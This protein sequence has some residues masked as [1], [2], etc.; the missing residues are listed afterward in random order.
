M[1][2]RISTLITHYGYPGYLAACV[3]AAL[4]QSYE[5]I[6]II[7]IDD[8]SPGDSAE[9][10]L[11]R[12]HLKVDQI[13]R[14]TDQVGYSAA[15]QLG[16]RASTGAFIL[17]FDSDD[18]LHREFCRLTLN[19]LL[20]ANADACYT[21]VRFFGD[22][23]AVVD[24][25]ITMVALL[26]FSAG[27][28]SI[29]YRRAMLE[30]VNGFR[31]GNV[32]TDCQLLIDLLSH[33]A[34]LKRLR[35]P[36]Y[37]Y[38]Q[39]GAGMSKASF[40]ERIRQRVQINKDLYTDNL[41][42]I[43]YRSVSEYE[44]LLHEY[45]NIL[46]SYRT[47]ESNCLIMTKQYERLLEWDRYPGRD[48]RSKAAD[49]IS[50][51]RQMGDNQSAQ[52]LPDANLSH[53]AL[54]PNDSVGLQYPTAPDSDDTQSTI[55][56][57]GLP[58][59]K[60]QTNQHRH[61]NNPK[62]I[63]RV[64][65]ASAGIAGPSRSGGMDA[66][67]TNL[68][69]AL[70][71]A[72]HDV[73]I[74]YASKNCEVE[75]LE[76][77]Q[78]EFARKQV[79]FVPLPTFL[80]Q[81]LANAQ[82]QAS[83]EAYIW[84]K[85]QQFDII[86]FPEY[87]GLGYYT[88]LAKRQGLA[89]QDTLIRIGAHSSTAWCNEAS[90]RFPD[91]ADEL[92]LEFMEKECLERA[93][94]VISPSQY[95]LNWLARSGIKLPAKS[96]V[97]HGIVTPEARLPER[98]TT[99]TMH[100]IDEIVFFGR[101]EERK[102]LRI[103]CDAVDRLVGQNVPDFSV[104]FMGRVMT[105]DGRS[106]ADYIAERGR[107]WPFAW[108]I[109]SDMDR[110]EAVS[111]LRNG[112]RLAVMPSLDEV[113]GQ[114]VMECIGSAIPF[115]TSQAGGMAESIATED[116]PKTTFRPN[117][118]ELAQKLIQVLA[119]GAYRARPSF[120]PDENENVW[121]E[122][123]NHLAA[124]KNS[125]DSAET[126]DIF[127][128]VEVLAEPPLVTV[129]LTNFDSVESLL[130]II[131][132]VDQQD[133]RNMEL[134]VVGD[135]GQAEAIDSLQAL[136]PTFASGQRRFLRLEKRTGEE[137]RNLAARHAHGTYL[138]FMDGKSY[139][140]AQLLST[141]IL[142]TLRTGA[143]ITTCGVDYFSGR[144]SPASGQ[145]PRATSIPLGASTTACLSPRLFGESTALVCRETFLR[146]G[147][148]SDEGS[149]DCK[150]WELFAKAV[151]QGFKLEAIPEALLWTRSQIVSV[152]SNPS[153]PSNSWDSSTPSYNDQ[154]RLLRIYENAVANSGKEYLPVLKGLLLRAEA[155]QRVE[156]EYHLLEPEYRK[157]LAAYRQLEKDYLSQAEKLTARHESRPSDFEGTNHFEG[158]NHAKL[159]L[160]IQITAPDYLK[161]TSA[162]DVKPSTATSDSPSAAAVDKYAS[163]FED[164]P[165]SEEDRASV[166]RQADPSKTAA[167]TEFLEQSERPVQRSLERR[168]RDLVVNTSVW[169]SQGN[170]W[171]ESV[172]GVGNDSK[173]TRTADGV[174]AQN[175][176]SDL[177]RLRA[178]GFI[179][180]A[181]YKQQCAR[182]GL[183]F[184]DASTHYLEE[185]W[186][187]ELS[188]S[189]FFDTAYYNQEA[190][191]SGIQI[192]GCPALHFLE[193]GFKLGLSP[194]EKF[195]VNWYLTEYPDV[196]ES[197]MNP[198]THFVRFG[199]RE[200]RKPLPEAVEPKAEHFII[201]SSRAVEHISADANVLVAL[202]EGSRTGA[203]MLAHRLL[204]E[205]K[206]RNLNLKALVAKDGP[207][208]AELQSE[209]DT[210][211]LP[212]AWA[213]EETTLA[214]LQLVASHIPDLS[215]YVVILSTAEVWNLAKF[216]K[217]R[218][219][220]VYT[221]IHEY[222]NRYP[223]Y[224][225]APIWQYS[226]KV[227]FSAIATQVVALALP[228]AKQESARLL[229]QGLIDEHYLRVH[230]SPRCEDSIRR[231]LSI[232]PEA[233]MVLC[234][235]SPSLRKGIDIFVR[236]AQRYHD[237]FGSESP[238]VFCWVG[239]DAPEFDQN[240]PW[241]IR[242]MASH[243]L[244]TLVR[245]IP[246]QAD[247]TSYFAAADVFL[248]PSR[249]D[250]LPNVVQ[251]AM[252]SALPVV[253]FASAGGTEEMLTTG[254]GKIVPFLD[255]DKM[256]TAVY[257]YSA[258][259]D[260]RVEDGAR[261]RH[262]IKTEY[263]FRRYA[264]ALLAD[265]LIGPSIENE[266]GSLPKAAEAGS[267]STTTDFARTSAVP[268]GAIA[269]CDGPDA[270]Q[271]TSVLSAIR[272]LVPKRHRRTAMALSFVEKTTRGNIR[273]GPFNGMKYVGSS[274]G[275]ALY[276][277]LLGT[278]ELELHNLINGLCLEQFDTI[279]NVGAAE[280][281]YAVG[282]ARRCPRSKIIAWEA[283]EAGRRLIAEL[284]EK[285]G[286][287]ERVIILGHCDT[288][289]LGDI[290]ENNGGQRLI[291]MDVEGAEMTLLDPVAVP[292][293]KE[294]TIL[295]EVH[296][297]RKTG[298]IGDQ[299]VERF[300]ATHDITRTWSKDRTIC[301]LPI[302]RPF[303][304]NHL[305]SLMDEGRRVGLC[306]MFMRPRGK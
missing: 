121:V 161:S 87:L 227:F 274:V 170:R 131:G 273:G 245:F 3:E 288:E 102:G 12:A 57:P 225:R 98:T 81:P 208:V 133:Y 7:V 223:D 78:A 164:R 72:G 97:Q 66:H 168:L 243:G 235:G 124:R 47:V 27:H 82:M 263:N 266:L 222:M 304:D 210:F 291:I 89:F 230:R 55:T 160:P 184:E 109:I 250:P 239:I 1:S 90:G 281:Y 214:Y 280:G 26:A 157:I 52:N 59:V 50:A 105:I 200:H 158:S 174:S 129:C 256:A 145:S 233:T 69:E 36:L 95:Y 163:S 189:Q 207:L 132:S 48:A 257:E 5:D 19:G 255:I 294:C 33:G 75:S 254:G 44:K 167:E 296:D 147:G 153:T 61:I 116:L 119:H 194:S 39:H 141:M 169:L 85:D 240:L 155:L 51:A 99:A 271:A 166:A 206:T 241:L 301:D 216:F 53:P 204:R 289:K 91:S 136:L 262:I 40:D 110:I 229:P 79:R 10:I 199:F 93:D 84:L 18:F 56:F 24:D 302:R 15:L 6:E 126:S 80:P 20:E 8:A 60:D 219:C 67:Y 104:T 287:S 272:E 29:L 237:K 58:T 270:K 146:L 193:E 188:P 305:Q 2:G 54:R 277:K 139:A 218:G 173:N 165:E 234:C 303:L 203:P 195:D 128:P 92:I 231:D 46:S 38:R 16:F 35:D 252:A 258:S 220:T 183:R 49:N 186:K 68:S 286:A 226:D 177:E 238:V 171:Q 197:G 30:Q 125:Y 265:E 117:A 181:F 236:L 138:L 22:I 111:Y 62:R 249:E 180:V 64:C 172:D 269:D 149:A 221:L 242:D 108:Q 211:V 196:K 130:Q 86:H 115:L 182:L 23:D 31:V 25:E 94:V 112:S 295:V 77:W 123:H 306:W 118:A 185:G 143:D 285:N 279:I 45:R 13:I 292:P 202:H 96:Y 253:A 34:I 114:V 137:P 244:N 103:F 65:S 283:E 37:W 175:V 261:G 101:L 284:A 251:Y 42:P 198:L 162:L 148:F 293:L 247:L 190:S 71:R 187:H 156:G 135:Q 259:K 300:N 113:W 21:A 282:M 246:S 176:L 275:S 140:K 134:I 260:L 299:L 264:D 192:S 120:D 159:D 151:T 107:R 215:S 267:K 32:S 142:A 290:L 152:S 278:Y 63:L 83:Y 106:A 127:R 276:P 179:N 205:L 213:D 217:E 298:P 70:A 11:D 73:T 122:W 28:Q 209:F 297:G 4:N 74:L 201:P 191:T 154:M 178:S 9:S 268:K 232:S 248:L 88:L 150:H 212:L 14:N 41:E 43:F 17:P 228:G 76:Y 224:A 100:P 144:S